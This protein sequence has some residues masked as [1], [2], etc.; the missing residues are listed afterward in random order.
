LRVLLFAILASALGAT[1][2]F[3]PGHLK[4]APRS[5]CAPPARGAKLPPRGSHTGLAGRYDLTVVSEGPQLVGRRIA[6]TLWLWQS[7]SLDS[8]PKTGKH[9]APRDTVSHPY[10]GATDLNLWDLTRKDSAVA[11][12]LRARIDPVYPQIMIQVRG[13]PPADYSQWKE[14]TLWVESVRTHATA[15]RASTGPV[16]SSRPCAWTT[17]GLTDGGVRQ[18]L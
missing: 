11:E 18:G 16:S 8:S 6:G 2:P 10:Y 17:T 13:W 9:V 15:P 12:S 3:L 7:S 5:P 4:H 1:Q 14:F